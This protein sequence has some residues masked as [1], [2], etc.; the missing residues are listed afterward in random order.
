MSFKGFNDSKRL[1][2]R[3]QYFDMLEGKR[4][5][6]M[7]PRSWK[8]SFNKGIV[9]PA[10]MRHCDECD[11]QIICMTCNNQNNENKA[12]EA[13]IIVLKQQTPNQ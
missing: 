5:S 6:A 7:L 8:K 13:N 10:K 12:S 3:S 11:D 1:S 4:I 9:I 2:D